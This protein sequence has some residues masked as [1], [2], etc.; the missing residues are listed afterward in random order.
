VT[1]LSYSILCPNL[2]KQLWKQSPT[3][4][5]L[6]TNLVRWYYTQVQLI[7]GQWFENPAVD[8]AARHLVT[9]AGSQ[10]HSLTGVD[11]RK[12][13]QSDSRQIGII[14][15]CSPPMKYTFSSPYSSAPAMPPPRPTT[16]RSRPAT[17][18]SSVPAPTRTGKRLSCWFAVFVLMALSAARFCGRIVAGILW[19]G[20]RTAR[21][22]SPRSGIRPSPN[23]QCASVHGVTTDLQRVYITLNANR[24]DARRERLIGKQLSRRGVGSIGY[25]LSE[26]GFH[27]DNENYVAPCRSP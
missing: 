7:L 11:T 19:R 18:S 23:P 3:K 16:T 10:Q 13:S 22:Q 24:L 27:S 15:G 12:P 26:V 6:L 5:K 21:R 20:T 8:G 25:S 14:A 4:I 1:V 2:I 9:T 17:S